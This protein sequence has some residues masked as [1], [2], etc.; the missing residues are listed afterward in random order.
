MANICTAHISA[1]CIY[2]LLSRNDCGIF[3]FCQY[4]QVAKFQ[5]QKVIILKKSTKRDRLSL[6]DDSALVRFASIELVSH[7]DTLCSKEKP[8]PLVAEL[9]VV[10]HTRLNDASP[11]VRR[12][13]FRVACSSLD[14]DGLHISLIEEL[15]FLV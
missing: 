15:R 7:L 10:V 8:S 2:L 13:A 11:V 4:S 5:Y 3:T 12:A 9:R 1:L 14:M 6:Q